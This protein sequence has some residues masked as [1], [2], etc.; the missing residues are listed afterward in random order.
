MARDAKIEGIKGLNNQDPKNNSSIPLIL[1]KSM[2]N[3]VTA[4]PELYSG[5]EAKFLLSSDG[6]CPNFGQFFIKG[7]T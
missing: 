1:I 3:L 2:P 4:N 5:N 6:G 7:E